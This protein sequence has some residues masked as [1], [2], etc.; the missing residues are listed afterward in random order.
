[1]AVYVDLTTTAVPFAVAHALAQAVDDRVG[2]PVVAELFSP[3]IH[4]DFSDITIIWYGLE[5]IGTPDVSKVKAAI[6]ELAAELNGRGATLS[7]R[8][9]DALTIDN[10]AAVWYLAQLTDTEIEVRY[11]DR[12]FEDRY[13]GVLQRLDAVCA[14][15]SFED[16]FDYPIHSLTNYGRLSS[17]R[18]RLNDSMRPDNAFITHLEAIR[19]LIR[20]SERVRSTNDHAAYDLSYV[21]EVLSVGATDLAVCL[22]TELRLPEQ[23]APPELRVAGVDPAGMVLRGMLMGLQRYSDLDRLARTDPGHAVAPNQSFEQGYAALMLGHTERAESALAAE[24]IDDDMSLSSPYDLYRL[25]ALSLLAFQQRKSARARQ[26]QLRIRAHLHGQPSLATTNLLYTNALNI[27]R[28]ARFSGDHATASEEFRIAFRSIEGV[29]LPSDHL[30]E[31][32]L[33][34]GVHEAA[35]DRDSAARYCLRA[36]LC[37]S[38]LMHKNGINWRMQGSIRGKRDSVGVAV[39]SG[40]LADSLFAKLSGFVADGFLP[41][42]DAGRGAPIRVLVDSAPRHDGAYLSNE[43]LAGWYEPTR[44]GEVDPFEETAAFRRLNRLVVSVLQASMPSVEFGRDGTFFLDLDNGVAIP[45]RGQARC[46]RFRLGL[47]P[48]DGSERTTDGLDV[49]ARIGVRLHPAV[50]NIVQD[51]SGWRALFKRYLA[52][53]KLNIFEFIVLTRLSEHTSLS[54]R[55]MQDSFDGLEAETLFALQDRKLVHL[56]AAAVQ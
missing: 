19:R 45:D 53:Q 9:G 11:T 40:E 26:L 2:G 43:L 13:V 27:G 36:S 22:A 1:V 56:T 55:A 31:A 48:D 42:D 35:G 37:W 54:L 41:T 4:L 38:T 30:Y 47:E 29:K 49:H 18:R 52:P 5:S 23:M 51:G 7:V 21:W 32:L 39:A 6:G 20:P 3:M 12:A 16:L 8:I 28:L 33:L 15:G 44:S 10:L 25:N 14:G 24:G 50:R 34:A 17:S 46:R